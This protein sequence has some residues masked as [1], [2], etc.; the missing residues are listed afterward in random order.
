MNYSIAESPMLQFRKAIVQEQLITFDYKVCRFLVV[1]DEDVR[2]GLF[3]N[4][5][6]LA[7]LLYNYYRAIE[8]D[9]VMKDIIILPTS[10]SVGE[11]NLKSIILEHAH[12]SDW[13]YDFMDWLEASCIICTYP[14]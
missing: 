12:V 13:S 11:D 7:K 1:E 4:S 5:V 10:F 6:N 2:L 3:F 14:N 8:G 9:E